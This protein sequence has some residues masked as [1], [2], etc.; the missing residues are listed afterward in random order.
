MREDGFGRIRTL[1]KGGGALLFGIVLELG[2]SFLGKVLIAQ[3][4]DR[5]D[6]G[7]VSLGIATAAIVSTLVLLGLD[8]GIGRYLP[9]Y[10]DLDRRRG[11]L[12][13]GFELSLPL[14]IISAAM[15][16]L[17]A[18]ILAVDVFKDPT[19]VPV[20]RVFGLAIPFGAV[21]KLSIGGIQGLQESF[22]KV[23]VQNVTFPTTRFVG[24]I[25]ALVLS[26]G[27]LGFSVAY[28]FSYVLAAV[29]GLYFLVTRTPLLDR[30]V[31]P[32]PIRGELLRFSLPLV[33]TAAMTIILSDIDMYMLG[34]IRGTGVVGDYNVIYPLAQLLTTALTAFGF[35]FVPVVSE[36]D[37]AGERDQLDHL[38]KLVT[39]WV[40][41]STLPV[42]LVFALFPARVIELTFGA[43][44]LSAAPSL[45]VLSIGF[46]LHTVF[47]LN[48]GA[49]TSLG[50]TRIIMYDDIAGAVVNVLLNLILIPTHGL[51][52]AAWAT[53][54]SYLVLN[55]LYS[56]QLYRQ[57]DV[58]PISAALVRPLAIGAV[59]MAV[60]YLIGRTYLV[61]TPVVLVGLF[62]VF[63]V[64]YG[65]GILRFGIEAE[66]VRLV[67]S[68]EERFGVD[69]G[70]LKRV[71]NWFVRG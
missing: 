52:G 36:L 22:P 26:Y 21:M 60:V 63:G 11:V 46:F 32:V 23:I 48:K 45:T 66:E 12:L 13:S 40:V 43:K 67:L 42:F 57:T 69:L 65:L 25:V 30:D 64:V 54:A 3:E 70:P 51:L 41:I 19:L 53:T 29:V 62:A 5:F 14:S 2:I 33:V 16:V 24:I 34:I 18:P 39:K 28:F 55:V 37:A 50:S 17:G 49:L 47:G 8:T 59:S 31:T 20:L 4:L 61:V 71:A 68:F 9:R 1:F 15:V 38:Y 35:L 7:S 56:G 10:D 27:V 44:Y 58:H 6:Y